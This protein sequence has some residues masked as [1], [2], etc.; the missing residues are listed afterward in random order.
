MSSPGCAWSVYFFFPLSGW[1]P[2]KG[3][4]PIFFCGT[5]SLCY[6][7]NGMLLSLHLWCRSLSL[8]LF[9]QLI[10]FKA[11]VLK[12]LFSHIPVNSTS[13]FVPIQPQ[14]GLQTVVAW[15]PGGLK[16]VKCWR[17]FIEPCRYVFLCSVFYMVYFP[18]KYNHLPP[19]ETLYWW[20][21]IV[22]ALLISTWV[23]LVLILNPVCF[24]KK[25]LYM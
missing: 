11:V 23:F 5:F 1:W 8:I 18:G 4:L 25:I 7:S 15:F 6:I 17:F 13:A 3:Y 24:G 16:S 19:L 12:C 21:S 14:F 22:G 10:R 20:G 2:V 9:G